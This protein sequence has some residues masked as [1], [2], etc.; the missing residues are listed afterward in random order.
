MQTIKQKA[1]VLMI[2]QTGVLFLRH[3][4]DIPNFQLNF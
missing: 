1:I 4:V 3:P 2:C